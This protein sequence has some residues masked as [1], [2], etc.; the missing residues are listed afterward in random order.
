[1]IKEK[2][3]TILYFTFLIGIPLFTFGYIWYED[4]SWHQKCHYEY[5]AFDG[6]RNKSDNCK[7][8]NKGIPYCDKKEVVGFIEMCKAEKE[9]NNA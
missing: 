4:Y 2:I 8:D 1:M 5:I 9:V 3:I 7:Y 6:S